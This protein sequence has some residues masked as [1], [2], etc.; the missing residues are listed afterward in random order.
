VESEFP[1]NS[2]NKKSKSVSPEPEE[3][4]KKVEK[5]IEGKVVR[6]KTPMGRRFLDTFVS[7]EGAK[8]VFG[9]VF[10]DVMIPAA[11]DLVVDA[12]QEALQRAF[13]GDSGHARRRSGTRYGDRG[14]GHVRYDLAAKRRDPREE[15]QSRRDR[16]THNFDRIYLDTRHEAD[17]VLE[18]L[19]NLVSDFD[20][21]SV[22]DLYDLLG[23][24]AAYTDR[25]WGW[26]DLEGSRIS[27]TSSGYLLDLPKTEPLRD[28]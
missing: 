1:S 24:T 6:R 10:F 19:Y 9:Y 18:G 14:G 26:T 27:H 21:A 15:R 23:E 17:E 22:A 16:A 12:G 8:S 11:R 4:Q 20:Q 28:T 2:H 25:K 13:Y 5:V 3:R 7:G